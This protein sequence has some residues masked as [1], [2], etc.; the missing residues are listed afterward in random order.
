MKF[1]T[2]KDAFLKVLGVCQEVINSKSPISILSN[3]CLEADDEF[4]YVKCSNSAVSAKTKFNAEIC[5]KGSTTVFCAKL[6]AIVSQLPDGNIEFETSEKEIQVKAEGKKIKYK[7]KSLAVDKF[8]EV[9]DF[10]KETSIEVASKDFKECIKETMFAVSTDSCRYMMT[11]C[12]LTADTEQNKITMVATDGKRMSLCSFNSDKSISPV[13]IPPKILQIVMM[14]AGTEGKIEINS[15]DKL[16]FVKIGN[17]E[18]YSS[19]IDAT[20]PNYK[21]VYPN[22]LDHTITVSHDAFEKALK[23]ACVMTDKFARVD[24]TVSN[25]K[26]IIES[27]DSDIGQSSEE[28][29]AVYSGED[30]KIAFNAAFLGDVLSV[31]TADKI[32]FDFSIDQ[33]N[34]VKSA[35]IIREENPSFDY[36][37]IVMPITC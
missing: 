5:E 13:I 22:G 2:S 25:N 37:H 26:I 9:I 12:Y 33:S 4:V 3:I 14:L 11:G 35:V 32:C 24:I 19:V 18:I 30:V 36:C 17:F 1:I 27:P 23:R 8:P 29:D 28:I 21:R 7:L 20:F 6:Y 34:I 16:F 31:L 15:T 10:K